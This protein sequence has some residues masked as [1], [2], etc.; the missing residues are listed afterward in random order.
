MC[1][2]GTL[3]SA[4]CVPR[5]RITRKPLCLCALRLSPRGEVCV[6]TPASVCGVHQV[7]NGKVCTSII[8]GLKRV[9]F[10]KIKPLETL[11]KFDAFYGPLLAESDFEAKPS[12]LLLG[13]VSVPSLAFNKYPWRSMARC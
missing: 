10:E 5:L 4:R 9:Y 3:H 7:A 8:D 2:W 6:F 12:V 1:S 11:F 13:Q